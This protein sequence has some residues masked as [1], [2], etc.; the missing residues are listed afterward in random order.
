MTTIGGFLSVDALAALAASDA[1]DGIRRRA[2]TLLTRSAQ[3][4]AIRKLAASGMSDGGISRATGLS[5]E[6]ICRLL[7]QHQQPLD[8]DRG[9]TR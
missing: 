3:I 6:M 7:T 5:T 4:E 8:L 2:F 9:D 1:G